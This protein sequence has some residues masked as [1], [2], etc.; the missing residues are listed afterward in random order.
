VDT[1]AEARMEAAPLLVPLAEEGWTDGE[2]P[3]LVVRRYLAPLVRAGVDALVL[4][5]THYPLLHEAIAEELSAASGAP[6]P[7]VDSAAATAEELSELLAAR[8]L[9]ARRS[10]PGR[11]R[12]LVTDVPK[13]FSD[14]ASR[15]LGRELS[16]LDVE[17]IDL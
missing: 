10:A 16:D 7:V 2:V 3:R 9:G 13:R 6:L 11:L 17:A 14:V 15:F 8:D 12:L 5:C 1:R 4:G